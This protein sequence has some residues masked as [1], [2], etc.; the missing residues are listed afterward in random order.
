MN[1]DQNTS[2]NSLDRHDFDL[3]PPY[4]LDNLK[5]KLPASLDLTPLAGPAN[6]R[7]VAGSHYQTKNKKAQHWDL[8]VAY[9]WDF[10][11][12]QI[13]KYVMRWKDKHATPEKRLEDLEKAGHFIQKYI[14]E[15]R[16]GRW[17]DARPVE[18][19]PP[20]FPDINL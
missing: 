11:Q 20:A 4:S 5:S 13:T 12:Y 19:T 16:A 14:E 7:Q 1:T 15:V 8:A 17:S 18:I 9:R 2:F 3:K 6:S 10:F